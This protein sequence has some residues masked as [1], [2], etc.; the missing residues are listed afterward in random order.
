MITKSYI[1][2][3]LDGG[4]VIR[5]RK[6]IKEELAEYEHERQRE[7]VLASLQKKIETTLI[8]LRRHM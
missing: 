6:T 5:R 8:R 1:N 3:I 2:V 4:R 7:R